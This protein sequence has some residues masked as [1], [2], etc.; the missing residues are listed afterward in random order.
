[1]A[2]TLQGRVLDF[3]CFERF[4]T[5]ERKPDGMFMLDNGALRCEMSADML[6]QLAHELLEGA[7]GDAGPEAG[8]MN[9]SAG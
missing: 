9:G 1:M 8:G 2:E 7:G 5:I 6:R 3:M 4:L